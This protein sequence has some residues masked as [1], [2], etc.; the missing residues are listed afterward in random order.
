MKLRSF[1]CAFLFFCLSLEASEFDIEKQKPKIALDYQNFV[2]FDGN[3][4]ATSGIEA[5]YLFKARADIGKFL[6]LNID[7][8]TGIQTFFDRHFISGE[9]PPWI[10]SN[11]LTTTA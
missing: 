9:L 4:V 10:W 1:L 8:Q 2:D 5:T 6:Y 11:R 7:Y 3:E